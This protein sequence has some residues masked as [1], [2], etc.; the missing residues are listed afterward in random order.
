MKKKHH[1][2]SIEELLK[3]LENEDL[4]NEAIEFKF[5]NPVASFVQAFKLEP[6]RE[7]IPDKLLFLLFKNWYKGASFTQRSFNGQLDLYLPANKGTH[8]YYA[9]NRKILD[10]AKE[11][12]LLQKKHSRPRHK[13]K[14]WVKHFETFLSENGLEPG[15]VY[16]E[17]DILYYIYNRWCD[18]SRKKSGLS[19]RSFNDMC[20]LHFECKFLSRNTINWFGVNQKVKDLVT[21]EEVERWRSGRKKNGKKNTKEN[22]NEVPYPKY[23]KEVLYYEKKVKKGS[24]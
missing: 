9:I 24:D 12:Q 1:E 7:K 18:D 22:R 2:I 20:K 21:K 15:N 6:G 14:A 10:L 23:K 4:S 17:R 19:Q 8:K 16:I 11:V 5:D 13:S 3:S